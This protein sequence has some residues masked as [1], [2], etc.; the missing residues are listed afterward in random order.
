MI[1]YGE[2]CVCT[3]HA[4]FFISLTFI[5]PILHKHT[6]KDGSLLLSRTLRNEMQSVLDELQKDNSELT[7]VSLERL[8][9]INPQLLEQI[10]QTAQEQI[11][12]NTGGTSGTSSTH[13]NSNS[14]QQPLHE[15]VL[16]DYIFENRSQAV[17]ERSKQWNEYHKT[18]NWDYLED[19]HQV[20]SSLQHAL[21]H[22]TTSNTARYTQKEALQ[23]TQYLA[24]AQTVAS[25]IQESLERIKEQT[26]QSR[27]K[28][29]KGISIPQHHSSFSIDKTQFTNDGIKK[30]VPNLVAMLL[31]EIGLP[32][33]SASDGQRFRTQV[34]LSQHLDQL[35]RQGQLEKTIARTEERGWYVK[36]ESWIKGNNNKD[37]HASS[38]TTQTNGDGLAD[39]DE[40]TGE[41][42]VRTNLSETTDVVPADE[43]RDRCVICGINFNLFFDNEEGA[44]MY[45]NCREI[46]V[47]NDEVALED[48]EQMLVHV[49]CWTSLGSPE[50]LTMDQALQ[51]TLNP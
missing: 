44:Y 7:K 42:K 6:Q 22:H 45:R 38:S 2:Y 46:E 47:L 9:E 27:T 50:V 24:A 35:F 20:V 25:L 48:S 10:K 39:K 31:Y 33:V 14:N 30:K 37:S 1:L 41:A 28:Q 16:P 3:R 12:T 4:F 5:R 23:M 51:D 43:N 40:D 19:S 34:E 18:T 21:L 29:R 32:F 36:E 13:N 15:I 49:T 11:Q 17:L 8:A 26:N